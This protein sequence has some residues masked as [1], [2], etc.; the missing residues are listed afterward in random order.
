MLQ[1]HHV[2]SHQ[3][4]FTL[5]VILKYMYIEELTSGARSASQ[6]DVIDGDVRVSVVTTEL[7]A[8]SRHCS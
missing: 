7:E 5:Y 2:T 1:K 8:E 3:N 4:H 6:H